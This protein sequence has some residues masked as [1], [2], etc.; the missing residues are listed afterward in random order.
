M[1]T[2]IRR[3]ASN[4][5]TENASVSIVDFLEI[6]PTVNIPTD[7]KGWILLST[8][9]ILVSFN[10]PQ[11]ISIMTTNS[12]ASTLV[13][14]LYLFFD[15][16]PCIDKEE[17]TED[18]MENYQSNP[19]RRQLL[20]KVFSQLLT[21]LC[22]SPTALSDLIKKDDL[23]LLFNVITSWCP[24]HNTMWRKTAAD[25]I[26]TMAKHGNINIDYLHEKN[27]IQLFVE[28]VQRIVELGTDNNKEIILMLRTFILFLSEYLNNGN[29]NGHMIDILL[30]DFSE[31]FGYQF[32]VDFAIKLQQ[33]EEFELLNEFL[34]LINHF[35]KIGV[36]T[37]KP[38]PMSVNQVFTIE[39][40][41]IPKPSKNS[42]KNLKAFGI[43]ISL[44]ARSTNEDETLHKLILD[45]IR[46]IF[47]EDKANYFL[48][49]SQ[50]TLS[51]FADKLEE[52]KES[53]QLNYYSLLEYIVKELNYVP[54]KELI[55]VGMILKRQ[56]SSQS[57]LLAIRSLNNL[58]KLFNIFKDV[59]RE[60][61]LVDILCS[62]YIY[63]IQLLEN[64]PLDD[65]CASILLELIE[66]MINILSG[67]VHHNC[68]IFH[69]CG[70]SRHTFQ[71]LTVTGQ[72][73]QLKCIRKRIFTIIQ[74]LILSNNSEENLSQLLVQLHK[75]KNSF[76]SVQEMLSLKLSV[77]KLLLNVL[78]E[79]HR[80]RAI[81]R[82][83]G[84]FVSVISV[85]V[86]MENYLCKIPS[87]QNDD[88]KQ[89]WNL[90]R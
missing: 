41:T 29:N 48:Q 53:I 34:L 84:G 13:K 45:N 80:V 38:R 70:A 60:V 76:E 20:Q 46:K 63:H 2:E 75:D 5:T 81:F 64:D 51:T 19:E 39:N 8:L 90:L 28:N 74:Q 43:F 68:Q 73:A 27:C 77:L 54:C 24:E 56:N 61:G 26:I 88:S 52:K 42:I 50:N 72:N 9:N 12:L 47:K 1:V 23:I 6:S 79:N 11:L 57:L 62:T 69:D 16:P 82:K 22:V 15:L 83:I 3:R 18:D 58:I 85:I 32:F 21:R 78:S 36:S 86:Y 4:K 31:C 10:S 7:K 30:D 40:F 14:C 44:W 37:L 71:I 87:N 66:I 33:S 67:P 89:I 55:T 17:L 35:T 49:E 25:A 65:Q 59:Y